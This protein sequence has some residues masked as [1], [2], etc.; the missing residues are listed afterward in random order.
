[1][2]G[3]GSPGAEGEGEGTE[4]TAE[5]VAAAAASLPD[6][7]LTELKE[8]SES[9]DLDV[10]TELTDR[11][12]EHHEGLADRIQVLAGDFDFDAIIRLVSRGDE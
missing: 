12:R 3:G 10:L 5:S 11:V 7:L 9:L 6:Q 1:M 4:A 2:G 8:A